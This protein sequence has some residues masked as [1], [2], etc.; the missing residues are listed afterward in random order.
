M[1][2]ETA[3][4]SR[5]TDYL[6][7]LSAEIPRNEPRLDSLMFVRHNVTQWQEPLDLA[8]EPSPVWL[9]DSA[10][11][12]DEAAKNYLRNVLGKSKIQLGE[13]KQEV[14]I[15]RREVEAIKRIRQNIRAGKDNRDEVELVRAMFSTQEDL[16]QCERKRLTAE[17]ES[18]TITSAVGDVSLGAQN[19]NFKSQTFKI[20]TNCDLCGDRIWGLSAKGFDCRDCGYTC[21]SK[22][23]LKVPASCP[24]ELSKDEKK[25]VKNERQQAFNTTHPH[26]NCEPPPEGVTELPAMSRSSTMNSLSSGYAAS[27]NRSVSGLPARAPN[28]E[29]SPERNAPRPA[30]SKPNTMRKNRIVAPPPAQYI[31]EMPADEPNGRTSSFTSNPIEQRGKMLYA[32]QANGAGEISVNEG[33]EVTIIEPDGT[34]P[35]LLPFRCLTLLIRIS[36]KTLTP[37]M[38][39]AG[40]ASAPPPQVASFQPPISKSSILPASAPHQATQAAPHLSL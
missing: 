10:M 31:S 12:V 35:L 27:A 7:H 21:H 17:V 4:L 39:Q 14:D 13:L 1:K 15:K 40:S 3:T 26:A 8:F 19:H 9:D 11:A 34:Q 18:Y 38:A 33:D 29:T 30:V 28:E 6:N 37:Q 32:Y 16:H 24:G 23:E 36:T 22:C 25:K 2:L 5:S 20:P